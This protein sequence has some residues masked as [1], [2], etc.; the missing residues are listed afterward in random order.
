[1]VKISKFDSSGIVDNFNCN[2]LAIKNNG[3]SEAL[4]TFDS[5]GDTL[6]V[7]RGAIVYVFNSITLVS[8]TYKVVFTNL[9][10]TNEVEVIQ[11]TYSNSPSNNAALS[12]IE[13]RNV[14]VNIIPDT[15]VNK[16][17]L[18]IKNGGTGNID[19]YQ[20]SIRVQGASTNEDDAI[21]ILQ[22]KNCA[23]NIE[24]SIYGAWIDLQMS[25]SG[26]TNIKFGLGT[27]VTSSPHD[28]LMGVYFDLYSDNEFITLKDATTGVY[29]NAV[30]NTWYDPIDGTGPSGINFNFKFDKGIFYF[31]YVYSAST[32]NI[33]LS[34][35][36]KNILVQQ[37]FVTSKKIFEN[38][39]QQVFYRCQAEA[40]LGYY[41]T[42]FNGCS[43][44][45]CSN[46]QVPR[47]L[48][49]SSET[50]KVGAEKYTTGFLNGYLGMAFKRIGYLY[51]YRYFT[52]KDFQVVSEANHTF[53]LCL[54]INPVITNTNVP[55]N[56]LAYTYPYGAYG[57]QEYVAFANNSDGHFEIID[58]D[59]CVNISQHIQR[60][61]LVQLVNQFLGNEID[62]TP[63]VVAI[64][65]LPQAN[66]KD[67]R[68]T[69]NIE[70][71]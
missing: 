52:L 37:I 38:P 51:G 63:Q 50:F 22:T 30:R 54:V 13:E 68:V 49:C 3:T 69:A 11:T 23:P 29:Y 6:S 65:I 35:E 5:T 32:V 47:T 36:D 61:D 44:Y 31:E 55:P 45:N 59:L 24:G 1:M 20:G 71:I 25:Y 16:Y 56:L 8:D 58:Y 10:T 9:N 53:S 42:F 57:T 4:V 64:M 12:R 28:V 17:D 26:L 39:R 34:F 41:Y 21:S 19:Y 46:S 66:N 60:S 27:L 7:Q 14:Y 15:G 67:F 2:A 48:G 70:E 62:G 43:I 18:S 33:Y 40:D